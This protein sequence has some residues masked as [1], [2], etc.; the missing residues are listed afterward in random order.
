MIACGG[1]GPDAK[2]RRVASGQQ[3]APSGQQP[4][5][6]SFA[7]E[8][9][10][11]ADEP[12]ANS[13]GPRGSAMQQ[14][15]G[16]ATLQHR[17]EAPE[18]TAPA[19]A[20][21]SCAPHERWRHAPRIFQ[22]WRPCCIIYTFILKFVWLESWGYND[23]YQCNKLLAEALLK[24]GVGDGPSARKV[25]ERRGWGPSKFAEAVAEHEELERRLGPNA[26]PLARRGIERRGTKRRLGHSSGQ[27]PALA[28]FAEELWSCADEPS[29]SSQGP[30]RPAEN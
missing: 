21:P 7:D 9:W 25:L 3:P 11:C 4:A 30:R 29:A 19:P 27:Q 2:R 20:L 1:S 17:A 24:E 10:S 13:Q 12:S 26:G 14:L 23:I 28:S 8:L 6:A 22:V 18:V 15:R 5:L 16:T